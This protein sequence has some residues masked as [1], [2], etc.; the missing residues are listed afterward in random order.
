M[1]Q[2]LLVAALALSACAAPSSYEGLAG[3]TKEDAA[4]SAPRPVSP[5]SVSLVAS[6][7]PRLRWDLGN[8]TAATPLCER[9][10]RH[11]AELVWEMVVRGPAAHGASDSPSWRAG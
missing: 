11:H 7:R 4:V 2:I 5:I 6:S 9:V 1:K 10:G 8:G 3:G